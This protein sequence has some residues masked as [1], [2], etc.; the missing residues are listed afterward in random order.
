MGL[1]QHLRQTWQ[2]LDPQIMRERLIKWRREPAIL[3]IDYPTR[4]DRARSLGYKAKQGFVLVR[5][6]LPRGG[7]QRE[8]FRAGRKSRSYGRRKIVNLS[9]QTV[10]EQRANKRYVNCEVLNSYYVAQDGMYD[11]YEIILIDRAHQQIL[12]HPVLR[13]IAAQRGR[14]YRGLTSSGK[15]S[16]GL[17]RKGKGA[18]KIRPSLRAHKGLAH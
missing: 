12:A 2:T 17:L 8:K 9:Y 15:K 5:V 10:A 14:V 13:N 3:R 16:R 18:E 6:R 7:R 4:L 11:W 1:Y